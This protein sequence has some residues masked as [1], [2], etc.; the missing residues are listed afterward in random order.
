MLIQQ[1]PTPTTVTFHFTPSMGLSYCN[2]MHGTSDNTLNRVLFNVGRCPGKTGAKGFKVRLVM[3]DSMD[4]AITHIIKVNLQHSTAEGI[5]EGN[6]MAGI[7]S[8]IFKKIVQDQ[9]H[10]QGL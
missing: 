9:T 5:K 3:L 8:S 6:M 2:S 10:Y 7:I 1:Q 4:Q